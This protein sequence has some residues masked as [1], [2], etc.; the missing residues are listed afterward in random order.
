MKNRSLVSFAAIFLGGAIVQNAQAANLY[1]D[2]DGVNSAATGGT[3]TWATGVTQWRDGSGTGTLVVYDNTSPSPVNAVF[4]GNSGTVTL[5]GTLNAGALTFASSGYTLTA[6]TLNLAPSVSPFTYSTNGGTATINSAI[7]SAGGTQIVKT[8]SGTVVLGTGGGGASGSPALYTITGGTFS[9][10]TGIFDS[11]LSMTF[12]SALGVQAGSPTT[13][14]TL[15]AGTLRI[16]GTGVNNAL[17]ANRR[18]QVNSAG[19]AITD[20]GTGLFY[21]A[22]IINNAG[23]GTSLYLSSSGTGVS[24]FQGVISG[25]GSVTWIGAAASSTATF[26]AANTYTG[27]TVV[28]LGTVKLDFTGTNTGASRLSSSSAIKLNAGTFSVQGTATAGQTTSQ[29]VNGLTISGSCSVVDTVGA[30]GL[31]STLVL[32]PINRTNF[33]TVNFTLPATGN[34]T[35]TKASIGGILGG[36]ATVAGTDWAAS[37]SDGITSSNITAY[38]SYLTTTVAGNTA[39]NYLS[40]SNVDVNS[41][42][43]VSGAVSVNSL[44]FNSAAANTLNLTGTNVVNAGGILVTANV[45]ANASAINGGT[46][47]G[48]AGGDLCVIQN[49]TASS[50]TIGSQIADNSSATALVKAGPGTLI[51]NSSNT[52]TGNT[53]LNAGILN[54]AQNNALGTGSLTFTSSATLQAGGSGASLPNAINL[55][56]FSNVFDTNGTTLTLTGDISNPS[57]A[58]NPIKA[59]GTGTLVLAGNLNITGNATDTN[60][61]A[62]MMGNRNGANFN[63][64]TVTLS[65]TGSIS[66]ISTGWDNTANVFNFASSGTV[67]MATDFVSGQSANGVGVLNV[68]SGTW[69]MQNL[70]MANWDGS[71]GGFTMS[72]GTLNT[73]NLRNGGNG[74]GN[75]NSYSIMTDGTVN[76]AEVTTLSRNGT[77]TNVL[78][79]KGAN[80]RFN[81]GNNRLNVGFS[82]GSTGIVTVDSGLLTVGSNLSI[83]EGGTGTT[84]IVNLN[85]GIIRPN[86]ILTPNGS[87][88]SIFNF[89]G[90]T[91]QANVGSANFMGGLTQANIY[92]GGAV[93]D[94]NGWSVTISQNLQPATGSGVGSIPVSG[95]GSGYLGIP[96]VKIT[97]GGGTG[98]TAVATISGGAVTGIQITSPGTG[99][100]SAPTVS[101]VGGGP[102]SAATV[103]TATLATNA[104]DGGLSKTGFGTVTLTGSSSYLGA[105]TVTGGDLA[106]TNLQPNGTASGIGSGTQLILNGGSLKYTGASNNNGFDRTITTG[107]NGSTIDTAIAGFLFY[108]GT[109]SG[110]D[111]LNFVDTSYRSGEFLMVSDSPGF[112][113]EVN[114]G[115]GSARS[116]MVQYRSNSPTP[117]GT[118]LIR[119]NG[120]GI[121]TSDNGTTNPSSLGNNVEL[122]GGLL[123]TQQANITYSGSVWLEASSSVGHPAAYPGSTGR[124]TLSGVIG[125]ESSAD[126]LVSTSSS[127]VLSNANTYEGNTNVNKG[128]LIVNGS[129]SPQST[130]FVA[131]GATLGGIGSVNGA[132]NAFGSSSKIAPGAN[133]IGTLNTGAVVLAGSLEV[134]LNATTSDKL[135][136]SGDLDVTGA[137]LNC[138]ALATPTAASYVI[139]QYTGTLTGSFTPGTLPSGYALHYDNGTREILLVQAPAG[140]G[141]YMDGFTGLSAADKLPNADPDHDGISNLLEYALDGMDPTIANV[142]PGTLTG[143]VVSYTKRALAVSNNDVTY[144]IL[145]SSTLGAEPSPWIEVGTYLVNDSTTISYLLPSGQPK[146]FVKLK[147]TQN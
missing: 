111:P 34:I 145:Q 65:G 82:A 92:S 37:T 102:T 87:G 147:V 140:F 17:A 79:L 125:G 44:R 35:S 63:R 8:G 94:S 114:I 123:A 20:T 41:T 55:G 36:W 143:Y 74:N 30:A 50:L 49:N 113:G 139:A 131:N 135:N 13:V 81:E 16:T 100:T 120:G 110:T 127:V 52:Y 133:G 18:V 103:G 64:G 84:G 97:G 27:D 7:T 121:L 138:T 61:P 124:I 31:G 56:A 22:P 130:V 134:E 32:G 62:L 39:G 96:V 141:S 26:Q 91:L 99:Y 54:V 132:V 10:G 15:D 142:S 69:N 68:T 76:V 19:G 5:S 28:N 119:V 40:S 73:T 128:T 42:P 83:A 118:G 2:A 106:T 85:G 98:A 53:S 45:G 93:I 57:A 137:T 51:L 6:G 1:W 89:N 12:G 48:S 105:T 4:A 29:T 108:Y 24:T 116:G 129:T 47:E 59:G 109:L 95:G 78:H 33:G 122:N 86:V 3:G 104:A 46:L 67:T 70:N 101:L 136:I 23:A 58:N 115:N 144:A 107:P 43:T 88:T 11:V 80:A 72:G 38:S 75:G 126:L 66:R 60:N 71:Y 112:S 25:T 77:G 21:P 146:V 14:L 9:A 117:F 90:G